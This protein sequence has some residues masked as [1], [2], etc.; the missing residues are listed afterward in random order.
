MLVEQSHDIQ[1]Q[2]GASSESL[3]EVS[4]ESM[5]SNPS[6]YHGSQSQL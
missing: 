6:Q 1:C 2:N 5:L 3:W 4:D